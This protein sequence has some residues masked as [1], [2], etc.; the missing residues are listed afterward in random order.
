M[1]ILSVVSLSVIG[2]FSYLAVSSQVQS[3][4]AAAAL[5]ATTVLE[6]AVILGPPDWGLDPG[7]LGQELSVEL[8]TG[9]SQAA[10][11]MTYRLSAELSESTPLGELYSLRVRVTWEEPPGRVERGRGYLERT[12]TVYVDKG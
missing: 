4:R 6:S 12:R 7:Q 1:G 5:L 10:E 9:D 11:D 3:E 8:E 2:I